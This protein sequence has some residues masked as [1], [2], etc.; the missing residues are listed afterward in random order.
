MCR[1]HTQSVTWSQR[2]ESNKSESERKRKRKRK[3]KVVASFGG[4]FEGLGGCLL[5]SIFSNIVRKLSKIITVGKF[6]ICFKGIE[7]E[8][9]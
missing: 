8:S 3:R 2:E 5:F 9:L 6:L 4:C 1:A 7:I